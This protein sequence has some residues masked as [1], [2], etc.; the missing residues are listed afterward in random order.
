MSN[1][2]NIRSI[3]VITHAD[4]EKSTFTD[5]FV[6]KSGIIASQNGDEIRC[7]YTEKDEQE[8]SYTSKSTYVLLNKFQRI[9]ENIIGIITTYGDDKGPM[10]GLRIDP[11]R[12]TVGFGSDRH[13]WAFTLK[14]FAEMYASKFEIVIDKLMKRLWSDT[15]VSPREKKWSKTGEEGKL[16][17]KEKE[18][19]SKRTLGYIRGFCQFVLDPI[20][21]IFKAT[22]SY[23]I[24]EY[25]QLLENLNIKLQ[26]KDF[27]ELEQDDSTIKTC[28][29]DDEIFLGIR[30]CDP[31]DPLMMCISKMILTLD[32]RRFYAFG[33]VFS[34]VMKSNQSVHI[35]GP[36]YVPGKNDH[37]YIQSIQ[38]ITPLVSV[39]IEPKVSPDLPKLVDGLN[40]LM[41]SDPIVQCIIEKSGE[42]ILAG[43]D[44]LHLD[45]CLKNLADEYA[46]ISIKVS[47]PIISYRESVS[48]ES[49]IMSLPKSPNK[50]N[51]IYL[52]ARPMPDGLPEDIDK[53]EVTSKQ[54]IQ[55]RARY[56][57]A[58]YDYDINGARKIWCFEPERTGPDILIDSTK[59]IQY[60]N[61][62]KVYCVI[63]FQWTTKEGIHAEENVRGV[64][65]DIHDVV[66]FVDAI[67]R[68]GGQIIP[69]IRRVLYASMLTASSRLFEPVYLYEI[70]ILSQIAIRGI[71]DILNRR[72]G[73]IFEENLVIG[74]SMFIVK[75]YIPLPRIPSGILSDPTIGMILL[76]FTADLRSATYG[77][78]F[79][80]FIFDHWEVINQVPFDDSTKVQQIINAI[81]KR[82]GLKEGIP[83]HWMIILTS[84]KR[85]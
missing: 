4:H 44:E 16:C 67:H 85:N 13:E 82:K 83:H 74:T 38:R 36:N 81:R 35:I 50:H 48:K 80:Q 33:R 78:G 45:V 61:E 5:L 20:F 79:S 63:G 40:R 62:I 27:N 19:L 8:R 54:D 22:M 41:K 9:V 56:L 84:C 66:Y 70:Q 37:L 55:A 53:G 59:G 31:Y 71:Y 21:K 32:R 64:R 75:A 34:G 2:K 24:D 65:F 69:T 18:L 17:S 39:T 49:E 73:H 15:F 26:D 72:R 42:H 10:G 46:C 25:T 3:S 60:L 77:Q 57:N 76:G 28:P 12:V 23:R 52:K 1:S 11:T 68:G 30:E 58:K 7:A 14:E 47:G 6:C 51:R 43:A 29:H